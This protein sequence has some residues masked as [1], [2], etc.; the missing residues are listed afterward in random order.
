MYYKDLKAYTNHWI[1]L[2]LFCWCSH[3]DDDRAQLD[4][5]QTRI[6]K[7]IENLMRDQEQEMDEGILNILDEYL[8]EL[9][10]ALIKHSDFKE[11]LSVI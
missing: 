5:H 6:L 9:C 3:D 11:E 1:E 2:I 7:R 8:I 10:M 4:K